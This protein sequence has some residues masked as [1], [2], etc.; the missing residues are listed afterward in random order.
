[1]VGAKAVIGPAGPETILASL[2][3]KP[4][5]VLH[6]MKTFR[7]HPGHVR[8]PGL[9]E[10]RDDGGTSFVA[11]ENNGARRD[12]I[13]NAVQLLREEAI[14]LTSYY[15]KLADALER[16]IMPAVDECIKDCPS[17]SFQSCV[18][19]ISPERVF[20]QLKKTVLPF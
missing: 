6:D 5:V 19:Y 13:K 18:E 12:Q 7:N 2:L 10:I 11:S 4:V 9:H 15:I 8:P 3:K 14:P 16:H 17:C 20:E 1:M